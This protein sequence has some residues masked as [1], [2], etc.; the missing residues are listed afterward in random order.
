M[1]DDKDGKRDPDEGRDHQEEPAYEVP[2]HVSI[3]Y[4]VATGDGCFLTQSSQ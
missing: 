2:D 1:R 4:W 3:D